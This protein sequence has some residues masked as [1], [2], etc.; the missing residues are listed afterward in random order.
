M[1]KAR[2]RSTCSES[3]SEFNALVWKPEP[4]DDPS[5]N[6]T[7]SLLRSITITIDA[8]QAPST[9]D[10]KSESKDD[11]DN[12]DAEAP[13]SEDDHQC[14]PVGKVDVQVPPVWVPSDKRTNAA[15]IYLYFRSVRHSPHFEC[16]DVLKIF[17]SSRFQLT[18]SFLPPDP[19]PERPHLAI[20]LD[21]YKRKDIMDIIDTHREDILAYGYFTSDDFSTAQL[22]ANSTF[23][24]HQRPPTM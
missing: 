19:I 24:Y 2:F 20:A 23:T 8:D 9:L 18:E 15:L 14:A 7:P 22:I 16:T 4:N 17:C 6:E 10:E 3:L 1:I 13:D 12:A 11:D 21:A 5:L